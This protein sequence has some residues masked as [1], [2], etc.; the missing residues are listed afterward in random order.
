[1]LGLKLATRHPSKYDRED[2][3]EKR[4]NLTSSKNKHTNCK[5]WINSSY[6]RLCLNEREISDNLFTLFCTRVKLAEIRDRRQARGERH[7]EVSFQAKQRW[8]Q[9]EQFAYRGEHLPVLERKR[10]RE[11]ASQI[12]SKLIASFKLY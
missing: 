2:R 1:M 4:N 8:Y 3:R 5:E 6:R 12:N 11:R 7:L 10:E 9:D